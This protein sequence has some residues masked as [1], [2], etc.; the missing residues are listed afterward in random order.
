MPAEHA[1]QIERQTFEAHKGEWA[2]TR[3]GQFVVIRGD[4]VAGFYEDYEKAFRSA[5]SQFGFGTQFF[6][7]QIYSTEPIFYIY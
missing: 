1:F 7:K 2:K 3:E 4:E 5:I 6:I